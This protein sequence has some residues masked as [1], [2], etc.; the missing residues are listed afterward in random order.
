MICARFV[1]AWLSFYIVHIFSV[2][3]LRTIYGE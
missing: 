3:S 2:F 1:K